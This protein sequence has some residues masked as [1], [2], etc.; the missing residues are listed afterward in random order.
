MLLFLY[1]RT[2]QLVTMACLLL[3]LL[4]FWHQSIGPERAIA[5][6]SS[7]RL[8]SERLTIR[9]ME[10][11]LAKAD[12]ILARY[13]HNQDEIKRFRS[14]FLENRDERLVRISSFLDKR[15]QAR[16]IDRDMVSYNVSSSREEDLEI[17]HIDLPL[18][19]R[20]RDIR[21][22]VGDIEASDL[23]LIITELNLDEA[24]HASGAVRVELS[25]ATYF[26]GGDHE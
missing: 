23:F 10:L 6:D 3:S 18:M 4:V 15:T 25:L 16:G 5:L 1:G 21:A 22:L 12:G 17:H 26:Q 9:K 24:S 20:Y 7:E 2:A 8:D 13:N 19:G 14:G 11:E